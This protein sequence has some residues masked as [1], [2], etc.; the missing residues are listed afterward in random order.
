M[1][2]FFILFSFLI[3]AAPSAASWTEVETSHFRIYSD[4][5]EKELLRY[6][7]QLESVHF[8]LKAATGV[9]ES[10]SR[11]VKV[12]VYFVADVGVVQR[13]YGPSKVDV[14]GYYHPSE[15]GAYTVVPRYSGNN[16]TFSGSTI[17]YHEY[18]HHFMLQYLPAAYPDWYVEGF[19]EIMGTASF[20]KKGYISFGK[21][22]KARE[23]ELSYVSLYPTQKLFD[24]SYKK[25]KSKDR[26]WTYGQAWLMAHYLTFSEPRR[27]QLRQYLA[28]INKGVSYAEAAKVFGDSALLQ[29]EISIYLAGRSFPYKSLPLPEGLAI[30]LKPRLLSPG[31]AATIE[32][33]IMVSRITQIS[34]KGE[35]EDQSKADIRIAKEK[36]VRTKWMASLNSKAV[37]HANDPEVLQLLADAECMAEDFEACRATSTK[38]LSLSPERPRALVRKAEALIGLAKAK[39]GDAKE[40]DLK[41]AR[42]LVLRANR[43]D[44]DDPFA[45]IAFFKSFSG[46]QSP[47]P[48]GAIDGL[49]QAVFTMPQVDSLRINLATILIQ[50]KRF[51]EA[52]NALNPVAFSPHDSSERK[53][54]LKLLSEIEEK[55]K[56]SEPGA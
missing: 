27:G 29:R 1:R 20:E 44:P 5:S 8:L 39:T 45:L 14:A 46:S 36:A 31:E 10:S 38:L 33:R 15:D 28:A 6:A 24:G 3:S 17:L 56:P 55:D 41:A 11:I 40:L 53:F 35:N 23:A 52:R 42:S 34:P 22:A 54:A 16:G 13:L 2:K 43:A 48:D 26:K 51:V 50:K 12:R 47:L 4:G 18:A 37:I 21:A 19:A 7:D 30:N 32:D 9:K 49:T 25:D